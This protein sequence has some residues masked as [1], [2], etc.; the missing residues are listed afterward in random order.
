MLS[1][2]RAV[3]VVKSRPHRSQHQFVER[4]G[5]NARPPLRCVAG[6]SARL[7]MRTTIED[8]GQTLRR[9]CGDMGDDIVDIVAVGQYGRKSRHLCAIEVIGVRAAETL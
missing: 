3:C 4:E 9:Q 2:Q 7:V 6:C 8:L 5:G 1:A